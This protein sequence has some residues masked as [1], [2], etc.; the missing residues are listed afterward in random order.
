M[1]IWAAICR[2][3]RFDITRAD[4]DRQRRRAEIARAREDAALARVTEAFGVLE[5]SIQR[6]AHDVRVR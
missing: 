1:N 6:S 3:F 2:F 4:L 5:Q